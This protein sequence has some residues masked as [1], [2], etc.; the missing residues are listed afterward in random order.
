M[1]LFA[2]GTLIRL[3]DGSIS[4]AELRGWL[5]SLNICVAFLLSDPLYSVYLHYTHARQMYEWTEWSNQ[6]DLIVEQNTQ[7][8]KVDAFFTGGEKHLPPS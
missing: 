8:V 5:G 1:F 6:N 4:K 2:R 7:E 3:P